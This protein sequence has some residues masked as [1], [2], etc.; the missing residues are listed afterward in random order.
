MKQFVFLLRIIISYLKLYNSRYVTKNQRTLM[1]VLIY[2]LLHIPI[3]SLTVSL[4]MVNPVQK[5]QLM[6]IISTSVVILMKLIS[7]NLLIHMKLMKTIST[8]I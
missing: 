4:N 5:K 8:N 6:K 7:M 3:F 2:G 1:D